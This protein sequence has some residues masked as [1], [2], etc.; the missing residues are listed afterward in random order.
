MKERK[1]LEDRG[2]GI[3]I[4]DIHVKRVGKGFYYK[5]RGLIH[6]SKKQLIKHL[7]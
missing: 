5:H 7:K 1:D 3:H 6:K 2:Y 4:K